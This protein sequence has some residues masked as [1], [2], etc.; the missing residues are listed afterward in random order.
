MKSRNAGMNFFRRIASHCI[1]KKNDVK[2]LHHGGTGEF[3]FSLEKFVSDVFFEHV[4]LLSSRKHF[5]ILEFQEKL[6]EFSVKEISLGKQTNQKKDLKTTNKQTL[7]DKS[8]KFR[9]H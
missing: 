4:N 8:K 2:L 6:L 5:K 3:C 1:E 9:L 7:N